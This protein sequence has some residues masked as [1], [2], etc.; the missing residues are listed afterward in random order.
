MQDNDAEKMIEIA[1]MPYI[2]GRADFTIIASRARTCW[3]GFLGQ[4]ILDPAAVPAFSL[5]WRSSGGRELGSVTLVDLDLIPEPIEDRG[6]TLQERVLSTRTVEF[7]PRQTRWTCQEMP[8]P[9]LHN[10]LDAHSDGWRE[11]AEHNSARFD[12]L[13]WQQLTSDPSG[14]GLLLSSDSRSANLLRAPTALWRFLEFL[15][16]TISSSA[17]YMWLVCGCRIFMLVFYGLCLRIAGYRGPQG[18]RGRHGRGWLST[19]VWYSISITSMS[20]MMRLANG[21]RS[22]WARR[23]SLLRPSWQVSRPHSV[24]YAKD[25]EGLELG[26]ASPRYQSSRIM[27]PLLRGLLSAKNTTTMS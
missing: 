12:P 25:R 20:M 13:S 7:G 2:Y 5:P 24:H 27:S 6:W 23:Y 21:H 8:R 26:D 22:I 15:K 11:R 16:D 1:K 19:A 3:E 9:S 17:I 4:R 14:L 18:T 10:V